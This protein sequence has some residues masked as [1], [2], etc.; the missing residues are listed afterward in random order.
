MARDTVIFSAPQMTENVS[1]IDYWK[2]FMLEIGNFVER[3]WSPFFMPTGRR[4]VE[5]GDNKLIE[6][7]IGDCI[8][9]S[10]EACTKYEATKP[11]GDQI[12]RWYAILPDGGSEQRKIAT[13]CFNG[14]ESAFFPS[15][16]EAINF[17]V[18]NQ[19]NVVSYDNGKFISI[20]YDFRSVVERIISAIV[21]IEASYPEVQAPI[22]SDDLT[23]FIDRLRYLGETK[24]KKNT[25]MQ[26]LIE[27]LL[28]I[29]CAVTKSNLL[30]CA[31][32]TIREFI[33]GMLGDEL[34]MLALSKFKQFK[35]ATDQPLF[36]FISYDVLSVCLQIIQS[37]SSNFEICIDIFTAQKEGV[38]AKPFL[39]KRDPIRTLS[40]Q[41][42][43]AMWYSEIAKNNGDG[44]FCNNCGKK[45]SFNDFEVDHIY[46]WAKGGKTEPTNLQPL[47]KDC[48]RKKGDKL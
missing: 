38:S 19:S 34:Y 21:L 13:V 37:Y 26:G 4:D 27:G 47:C 14:F 7:V 48:N 44:V 18:K 11:G 8:F 33:K 9:L 20:F 23:I 16:K 31:A 22:E 25:R 42:K 28:Q 36:Y 46:P 1:Q 24:L 43:L 29:Y 30:F 5:F 12:H 17:S 40:K 3:G 32:L 15:I 45:L 39:C 10:P 35:E 2:N 6:N 41:T